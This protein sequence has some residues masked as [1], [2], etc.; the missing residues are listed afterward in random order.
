M[1][2]TYYNELHNAY[3][4]EFY[5]SSAATSSGGGREGSDPLLYPIGSC[6]CRS[7]LWA[8]GLIPRVNW[9]TRS[10]CGTPLHPK[11]HL[12]CFIK[13]QRVQFRDWSACYPSGG[14]Y[15]SSSHK[16][17]ST[18]DQI[19]NFGHSPGCSRGIIM[20]NNHIGPFHI[21]VVVP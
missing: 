3:L 2:T 21:L 19:F 10:H 13:F 17:I 7:L 11:V 1:R 9:I 18:H 20:N 12:V 15:G 16:V 5:S 8:T 14:P 6:P 4:C